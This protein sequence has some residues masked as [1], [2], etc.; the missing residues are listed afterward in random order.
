MTKQEELAGL[1]ELKGHYQS[2]D[3][4]GKEIQGKKSALDAEIEAEVDR[5]VPSPPKEPEILKKNLPQKE[6]TVG[7]PRYFGLIL[8]SL[9]II[10][11]VVLCVIYNYTGGAELER[12]SPFEFFMY[13]G[14]LQLP[15]VG[16]LINF[17]KEKSSYG[18]YIVSCGFYIVLCAISMLWGSSYLEV[19]G[20]IATYLLI[21]F[22][23][24]I[25]ILA[26][27]LKASNALRIQAKIEQEKSDRYHAEASYRVALSRAA[28]ERKRIKSQVLLELQN[29]KTATEQACADLQKEI[30][31]HKAAI[32]ANTILHKNFHGDIDYIIRLM[33][34]GVADS[35]KEALQIKRAEDQKR[36][37]DMANFRAN[38]E[39]QNMYRQ[40]DEKRRWEEQR[41]QWERDQAQAERE[42]E[43]IDQAK[44]AADELERI[45][46]ELEN[47]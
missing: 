43:R 42:R 30:I 33:E 34:T 18:E 3:K 22:P 40:E 5:R 38:L 15:A 27:V 4:L 25:L 13:L 2:I 16:F 41:A 24:V 7:T 44:R 35:V 6:A 26:F 28:E 14:I 11:I 37:S 10:G 31:A 39:I 46:K 29:K 20:A 8:A 32:N 9:Q 17:V 23:I 47:D 1:R 36:E 21:G 45:R 12:T 19:S